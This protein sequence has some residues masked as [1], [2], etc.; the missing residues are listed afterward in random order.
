VPVR[1]LELT[2]SAGPHIRR[3][4]IATMNGERAVDHVLVDTGQTPDVILR[5]DDLDGIEAWAGECTSER[6]YGY[7]GVTECRVFDA[8]I[9]GL[10]APGDLEC[11]RVFAI[12]DPDAPAMSIGW[13][14]LRFRYDLILSPSNGPMV[15]RGPG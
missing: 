9:R 12:A 4:T 1:E 14:L 11:V 7:A 8:V 13:P 5:V 10:P 6:L 2:D 3:L 15:L